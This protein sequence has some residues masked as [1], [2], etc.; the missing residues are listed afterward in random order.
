MP[1]YTVSHQIQSNEFASIS[2]IIFFPFCITPTNMLISE[3]R[4]SCNISGIYK[5]LYLLAEHSGVG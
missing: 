2:E 4:S 1:L 3:D 5:Q